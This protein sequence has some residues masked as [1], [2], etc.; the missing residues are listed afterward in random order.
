MRSGLAALVCAFTLIA[1]SPALGTTW[2]ASSDGTGSAPCPEADPCDL[3]D[4]VVAAPTG[5]RVVA[6]PGVYVLGSTLHVSGGI[7]LRGPWSGAPA[8]IEGEGPGPAVL[9]TGAGTRVTDLTALQS[10]DGS[11]LVVAS[12]AVAR[13][14]DAAASGI[15]SACV[16]RLGTTLGDSVCVA[17]G[18]GAGVLVDEDTAV[19]GVATLS[20]ITA[21]SR[22]GPG[23]DS[24]A[25]LVRASNGADVSVEGTNV[26][27]RALGGAPDVAA[28]QLVATA[29]VELESSDFATRVVVGGATVT[30]PGSGDNVSTAPVFAD[31][32]AGDFRQ[33]PSSPTIDSGSAD[34]SSLGMLDADRLARIG[35][36]APDIGAYEFVPPPDTRPPNVSIPVAPKGKIKTTARHVDVT[37]ELAAD[38]PDV[39]FECRINRLPVETCTSPVSYRLDSAGGRGAPYKLTVRAIDAAGNRSGRAIRMVRVIR[40]RQGRG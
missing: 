9:V 23:T 30:E 25:L 26:I 18:S 7:L 20:N 28:G 31:V 32:D 16:V 27:A 6:G 39:T 24:S 3:E 4:A 1:A 2:F 22:G 19:S 21:I 17:D 36:G 29:D 13:R 15:G 12:G 10:D 40:V 14:I 11:G 33:D 37:F 34:A 5:T 38:E 8:V 35:G